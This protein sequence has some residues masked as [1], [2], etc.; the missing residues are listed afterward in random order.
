MVEE[1]TR[2]LRR[3]RRRQ[4]RSMSETSVD[5]A[6][7]YFKI[8]ETSHTMQQGPDTSDMHRQPRV[9]EILEPIHLTDDQKRTLQTESISHPKPQHP[10]SRA[11]R[12]SVLSVV[13]PKTIAVPLVSPLT[14]E[15]RSWFLDP[16]PPTAGLSRHPSWRVV[17]NTP[18]PEHFSESHNN[19]HLGSNPLESKASHSS[20]LSCNGQSWLLSDSNA[21]A[22]VQE[23]ITSLI[24]SMKEKKR[25]PVGPL[26]GGAYQLYSAEYRDYHCVHQDSSR[27]SL[28]VFESAADWANVVPEISPPLEDQIAMQLMID[29]GCR[30]LILPFKPPKHAGWKWHELGGLVLN[31][32]KNNE[33]C[34]NDYKRRKVEVMF[35][36]NGFLKL[37][38]RLSDLLYSNKGCVILPDRFMEFAG[39]W[40]STPKISYHLRSQ[41]L[42]TGLGLKDSPRSFDSGYHSARSLRSSRADSSGD[43]VR[44]EKASSCVA[45]PHLDLLSPVS[46]L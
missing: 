37:R 32:R 7:I 41:Q 28:I 3:P 10:R 38:I 2:T 22:H 6:N 4:S 33:T 5:I 46:P 17:H 15:E 8:E 34:V 36:G 31:P 30:V 20:C 29:P 25:I 42:M 12:P 9:E 11:K 23:A 35:I 44:K 39:I 26:V 1:R 14:P 24:S 40:Q 43:E 27:Q 13:I 45:K 16:T 18:S 19:S 21:E